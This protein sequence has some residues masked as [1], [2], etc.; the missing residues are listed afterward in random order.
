MR[1]GPRMMPN[2]NRSIGGRDDAPLLEQ[3]VGEVLPDPTG[4][5]E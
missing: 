2:R 3:P 4:R 5:I 1:V